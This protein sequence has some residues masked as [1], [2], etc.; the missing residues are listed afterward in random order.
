MKEINMNEGNIDDDNEETLGPDRRAPEDDVWGKIRNNNGSTREI[1][2][3]GLWA[4]ARRTL[5]CNN[6]T[7]PPT[8]KVPSLTA[9][10]AEQ[11]A[12]HISGSDFLAASANSRGASGNGN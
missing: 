10:V 6:P 7:D 4:Y 5:S 2:T 9:L 12:K 11:V 1:T 8:I 3:K